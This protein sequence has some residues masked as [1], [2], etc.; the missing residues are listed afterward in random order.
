MILLTSYI[1]KHRA[2]RNV[3][4]SLFALARIS[5][6][7]GFW[8]PLIFIFLSLLSATELQ[9]VPLSQKY[10][11]PQNGDVEYTR[12]LYLIVLADS[13]LLNYLTN[14]DSIPFYGENF[15]DFKRTQGYDVD[16]ISLDEEG[17]ATADTIKDFLS[18]YYE[19]NP[20]LEYVLLIGDVNGNYPIPTFFIPSIN[21]DEDDV[22]DYPYTYFHD[23]PDSVTYDVLKPKFFI[24]RWSVRNPPDLINVKTRTIQYTKMENLSLPDDP[25][26]LNNALLVAGNYSATN[27]IP[28]PPSSWPVTPV[29]TSLWLMER[30]YDFGYSVVDTAF[31][32]IGYQVEDNPLIINSWSGGVGVINYR[33]WGNSHG[34]LKPKFKIEDINYLNHGWKL[35]IVFSFV[36]NTADFGADIYPQ[37][38][39]AKCFGEEL[40]T[41]GTP[42]T[43][44]KGAAAM[45]GPSDLDTDT[46]Y[47]NVICGAMWDKLLE[48]QLSELGPALHTGKNALITEF[49]DLTEPGGAVEFYHHIYGILGDPSISVW[50]HE[51]DDLYADI[52][53][54]PDLWQSFIHTN[55]TDQ[56]GNPQED[57]V[58]ALLLDG[59]LI[60]KGL[61]TPD[62][63]LCIDFPVISDSSLLDLYLNKAQY[64]QKHISL[65]FIEDDGTPYNPTIYTHFDITPILST[66]NPYVQAN[67]VIELSINVINPSPYNYENVTVSLTELSNG[68]SNIN[69]S[70]DI[71]QIDAFSEIT[72][73]VLLSGI[74]GDFAKGSRLTFN[75]E[76]ENAG[77]IIAEN[78]FK[79]LIGPIDPSDPIPPCDY[80]YWTYDNSDTSY[81]EAPVYDWI[82]LNPADGGQG[83]N[84]N[85]LDDTQIEVAI[86]FPF[87]YFGEGFDSLTI[88]SNGWISFESSPVPYFWNFSIP[89]SMGPPAMAAP[90]MDDLDDDNGNEPFDVFTWSDVNNGQFIVQWDSVSNGEDDEFCPDCVKE[91]FQLILYNPDI[92]PTSSGDGEI[93]FQYQEIY[94][95]DENGNYSTIGIESP[96]QNDGVQYL[97]HEQ[98]SSGAYWPIA[99]GELIEQL[100]V[101][102]TTDAPASALNVD[103]ETLIKNYFLFENYPN[104]FNS[105]TTLFF[106]IPIQGKVTINIYNILGQCIATIH[107]G[108]TEPGIHQVIWNG[109]NMRGN[110]VASG[111]YLYELDVESQF[112]QVK[113]MTLLK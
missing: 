112:H 4:D 76:F 52:E 109:R 104:P 15:I 60:G 61:S 45:I 20:L 85:L 105:N 46:R 31:F 8:S 38:G 23:N 29:W 25:Q 99:S 87:K 16:L 17:L 74:V 3:E 12:G 42:T 82:E 9:R 83:T 36:C 13:T 6:I 71:I 11:F 92:Y 48:E 59:E 49:P 24:G 100:A 90:F 32:H 96:D 111:I 37:V 93:L 91:T 89:M 55:V 86:G 41:K 108:F 80:G 56:Y 5:V 97:F 40:I 26:Y 73:D 22:T 84:L 58:G 64:F 18:T 72:T 63:E 78:A 43:G 51:P 62:G 75:V 53:N 34:W 54:S 35:P 88:C 81:D 107:N 44:P 69:N 21:E 47:N 103:S 10:L 77:E 113:K 66:G 110:P 98:P 28:D 70:T 39:P 50:L 33:G 7:R 102:F 19:S 2:C 30:M 94:D 14:P 65:T 1:A 95:I 106:A 27:G 68:I 79:I 57:V 67:E 101:K